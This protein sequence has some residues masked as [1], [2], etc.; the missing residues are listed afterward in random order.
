MR[1]P[2]RGPPPPHRLE[3]VAARRPVT[4]EIDAVVRARLA[5]GEDLYT[6]D[7]GALR[8]IEPDLVVTQDL[9][10]VCAVDIDEVDKAL[11]HLGCR[12]R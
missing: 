1:L 3:H 11:E 10:A 12:P 8:D 5:A 4:R 7:E 9:C 6:L 2:P